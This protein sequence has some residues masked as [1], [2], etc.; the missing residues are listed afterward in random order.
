MFIAFCSYIYIIARRNWIL[1][2][3]FS[4]ICSFMFFI[5]YFSSRC[6]HEYEVGWLKLFT[7]G[8]GGFD[9]LLSIFGN[10]SRLSIDSSYPL[11]DSRYFNYYIYL[12]KSLIMFLYSLMCRATS[13]LFVSAFVFI[14]FALFYLFIFVPVC[15]F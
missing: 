1:S 10:L 15:I 13:F 3:K 8:R 14:F 12:R 6:P 9:I 4:N 7:F 11:S 5:S 2:L